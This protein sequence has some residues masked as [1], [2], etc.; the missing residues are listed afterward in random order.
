MPGLVSLAHNRITSGKSL[1][2]L[3]RLADFVDLEATVVR[4]AQVKDLAVYRTLLEIL[5]A[6]LLVCPLDMAIQMLLE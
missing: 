1:A 4:L 5:L 6:L 3:D 2:G